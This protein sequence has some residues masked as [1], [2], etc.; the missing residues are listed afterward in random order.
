MSFDAEW[1]E[2]YINLL[3]DLTDAIHRHICRLRGHRAMSNPATP[4]VGYCGTCHRAI[5]M[6]TGEAF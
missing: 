4:G 2:T 1:Q 6:D 3:L 5:N